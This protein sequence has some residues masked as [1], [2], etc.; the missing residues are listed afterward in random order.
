MPRHR[1]PSAIARALTSAGLT[2]AATGLGLAAV[3][4]PALASPAAG[5][6]TGPGG[7][8]AP[9][10]DIDL[11]GDEDKKSTPRAQRAK[12]AHRAAADD[13]RS[14]SRSTGAK[15]ATARPQQQSRPQSRRKPQPRNNTPE[16]P[17]PTSYL[18]PEPRQR[19]AD[20]DAPVNPYYKDYGAPYNPHRAGSHD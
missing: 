13:D 16:A 18:T 5:P 6:G 19:K 1:A 2:V 14:E 9:Q 3:A 12:P 8:I 15:P 17:D 7:G 4:T 20:P 11:D 10:T